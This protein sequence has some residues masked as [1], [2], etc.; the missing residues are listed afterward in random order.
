MSLKNEHIDILVALCKERDSRA[1]MALYDRY[2]HAMFNTAYR[3]VHDAD[4]AEDIMQESFLSAFTKI[5]SFRAEVTFGA[6]LKKIVVNKSIYHYNKKAKDRTV[7]IENM[8][9]RVEDNEGFVLEDTVTQ[10]K[11]QKVLATLNQ[12]KDNYRVS[13]TLHLI[14]GYDYEEISQIM[15]ISY[16]NCRTLIS[17][18]KENLRNKMMAV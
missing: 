3:I 15:N 13:L 6:W 9:Y 12:L 4:E 16:G 18:A 8:M 2:Y 11:A 5:D 17:R 1:Q 14:E 7:S 10:T